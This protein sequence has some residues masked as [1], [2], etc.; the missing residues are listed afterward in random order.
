MAVAKNKI[1]VLQYIF[2]NC[3]PFKR[4]L[5]MHLFVV[6]F[7]AIDTSLWPYVSKLLIDAIANSTKENVWDE[8][9]YLVLLFIFLTIL[10][11]LVWRITDLSWSRLIPKMRQ[12]IAVDACG[13]MLK[14]SY[15]FFYKNPSGSLTNRV[16][17]LSQ[18]TTRLLEAI[19]YSFLS[20]LLSI[21]VAFYTLWHAHKFFAFGLVIWAFIFIYLA[22]KALELTAR[23]SDDVTTSHAKAIGNIVDVFS[24]IQNVKF[25][26]NEDEEIKRISSNFAQ[27]G[28][29]FKIRGMFLVRFYTLH[30]L[31]FSVYFTAAVCALMYLYSHNIITLGDFVLI[32]TINSWMINQMWRMAGQLQK[33]SEDFGAVDQSLRILNRPLKVQ[34]KAN[35]KDL[36]IRGKKGPKIEF[37]NVEFSYNGLKNKLQESDKDKNQEENKSDLII[38]SSDLN[39]KKKLII[40]SGQKVG[41]VGSSGSGKSTFINLLMRSYDVDDGEILIDNQNVSDVTQNSLRKQISLVPQEP[42]LFHRSIYNNIRYA[43][44]DATNEEVED[45]LKAAYCT[46]FIKRLSRG[47]DTIVGDRGSRISGG[48]KQRLSIARAFLEDCKLLIM[49]ESTSSLD[50]VT[51][52]L[53][54]RGL[55]KLMKNK[56]VIIAAHKLITLQDMDRILVFRNGK[57]VED[58]NHKQLIKED[59]FYK[60]MWDKQS[61]ESSEIDD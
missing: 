9:K 4:L 36:K 5:F 18:N 53:I 27:Y 14:K 55:V 29:F 24:N 32:F 11:G 3:W 19:L 38:T 59:G 22:V 50:S 30:G 25:Y 15:D 37:N 52:Q 57:I 56:T 34:D 20:I 42:I 46:Q 33:F 35:A 39:I 13:A 41:L 16:K 12:K 7:N 40:P 48:Q 21:V 49:D 58:G 54:H 10:P 8:T 23:M 47:Y 6:A 31:L 43:K 60:K 17:D 26:S 2:E 44:L 51:E 1:R 45:A 28:R 61:I